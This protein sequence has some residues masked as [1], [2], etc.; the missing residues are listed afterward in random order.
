M[1]AV[2]EAIRRV[3]WLDERRKHITSSDLAA[4]MGL[5]D[6]YG[7]PMGVFLE[8]QGLLERGRESTFLEAG[9][10]LQPVILE[11]YADQRQVAIEHSDPYELTVCADHPILA[12]SLDA[13]WLNGDRRCVDAKNVRVKKS[14][15]WGPDDT[16]EIPARFVVQ[17]HAQM[18]CTGTREVAELATL[19]A[20]ADPGKFIVP[21]DPEIGAGIIEAAETFWAKHV[22][23]DIPPPVDG[24]EEW[25]RWLNSQRERRAGLVAATPEADGWAKRLRRARSIG[26]RAEARELEARNH[27]ALLI[28]DAAGM[29]GAWGRIT[30][31]ASKGRTSVD[32]ERAIEG[33]IIRLNEGP[34]G[35]GFSIP[36]A[37]LEALWAEVLRDFT[38]TKPGT[39]SF[40][41]TF[42]E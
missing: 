19:F 18:E 35:G 22:A 11:W 20:G 25:T 39:R 28:G 21:Y 34:L 2:N 13:R 14:E 31:K 36:R 4:I 9:L 37:K 12:A 8:K 1:E 6:A 16:D 29:T 26:E 3:L 38:I 10:R 23:A 41:P 42:K 5:P 7:S 24:T 40:R 15:D 17:L 27:L 30:Y 32:L 33:F